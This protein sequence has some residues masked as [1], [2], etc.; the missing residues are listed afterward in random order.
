[1]KISY[2]QLWAVLFLSN[3]FTV[4]CSAVSYSVAQMTGTLISVLVQFVLTVPVICFLKK[5]KYKANF[6][7]PASMLFSVYFIFA[8]MISFSRMFSIL[9]YE[10]SGLTSFGNTMIVILLAVCVL[11]CCRLGIHS[12][13]RSAVI[14]AGLFIFFVAVLFATS[15]SQ[16]EFSNI[17]SKY[18]EN[19]VW[20]YVINDISNS[21]ELPALLILPCFAEK[22]QYKSIML[23]FLTKLILVEMISF[24]GVIVLGRASLISDS[25]FFEICSFSQPLSV[26]RS[27]ALFIGINTLICIVNITVDAVAVSVFAGKYIKYSEFSGVVLMLSGGIWFH[28]HEI[29]SAGYLSVIVMLMLVYISVFYRYMRKSERGVSA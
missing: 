25:P 4:I 11:Y 5:K 14:V 18:D 6:R 23:Y 9:R 20:Y 1:M 3:A 28:M 26:Q 19:S 22:N 8:G 27:D 17:T 15:Y 24:L 21:V 10:N 13:G 16:A 29:Y 7:L 12:A 2:G